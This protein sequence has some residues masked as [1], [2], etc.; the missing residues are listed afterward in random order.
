MASMNFAGG[1]TTSQTDDY[2]GN[3]EDTSQINTDEREKIKIL[4]TKIE[5]W[6]Q[7]A[8]DNETFVTLTY[9]Q[10]LDGMIATSCN[11]AIS[12]EESFLFTHGIRSIHDAILIGGNT[13]YTDNPRLNNRLWKEKNGEKLQ[14][15]P[16]VLDTELRNVLRMV[17]NGTV[18]KAFENSRGCVICCCRDA[19]EEF[20]EEIMKAAPSSL[21]EL[22]PVRLLVCE[23]NDAQPN[24]SKKNG[25]NLKSVLRNLYE[26]TGIKSVMVEGGSSIISAFVSNEEK[27]V[28]CVCVTIAPKMFGNFNGLNALSCVDL[29]RQV[30]G[31]SIHQML[32]FDSSTL[33]WANVGSDCIFLAPCPKHI[34]ISSEGS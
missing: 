15:I 34:T 13:L 18:I 14:P 24:K 8:N 11:V 27:L 12:C 1:A 6:K 17:R 7:K 3:R 32:E 5:Q 23:R 2:P 29:R 25:L 28:D 21:N 20:G 33:I 4:L 9:A 31:K 16:V 10:T 30:N 26:E 22:A 19:Y